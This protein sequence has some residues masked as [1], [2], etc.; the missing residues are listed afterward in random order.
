MV[1][2]VKKHLGPSYEYRRTEVVGPR[3]SGELLNDGILATYPGG[4]DDLD[5]CR[6]AL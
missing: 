6:G 2:A 3:V 5:L 1:G 4:G